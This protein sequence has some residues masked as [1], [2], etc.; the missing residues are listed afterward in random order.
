MKFNIL[1][2]LLPRETKF[3]AMLNKQAD[4]LQKTSVEFRLLVTNLQDESRNDAALK[5]LVSIKELVKSEDKIEKTI[6]D[7]LDKTFIT[8]LDREDI[9]RIAMQIGTSLDLI[10]SVSQMLDIYSIHKTPAAVLSFCDILVGISAENI[11]LINALEKRKGIPQIVR[12]M[13]EF[14]K[15]GDDLFHQGMARL[16]ESESPIEIIKFKSVYE[17]LE[18]TIDSVDMIGKTIRSIMIKLG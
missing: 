13:H 4:I 1:D 3:Y 2:L 18:D 7:E 17:A 9:N 5:N 11:N 16:F 15:R 6:V 14:E 10:N 8:P 12:L